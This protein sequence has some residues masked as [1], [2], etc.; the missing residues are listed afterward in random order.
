M[1]RIDNNNQNGYQYTNSLNQ[2]SRQLTGFHR[3]SH[4][5]LQNSNN[6]DMKRALFLAS[7]KTPNTNYNNKSCDT[8]SSFGSMMKSVGSWF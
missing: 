4:S 1:P 5:D 3:Y 2:S 7:T 6:S 8:K